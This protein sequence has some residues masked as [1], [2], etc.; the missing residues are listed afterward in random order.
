M[1]AYI[2]P[3]LSSTY[4]AKSYACNTQ[5]GLY[6]PHFF[7]VLK[8]NDNDNYKCTYCVVIPHLIA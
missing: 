3:M 2:Y 8:N 4:D 5:L 1:L 6:I 7:V